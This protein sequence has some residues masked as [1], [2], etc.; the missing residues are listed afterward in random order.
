MGAYR[1]LGRSLSGDCDRDIKI[2]ISQKFVV[3]ELPLRFPSVHNVQRVSM[4]RIISR[5]SI[6]IYKISHL[7]QRISTLNVGHD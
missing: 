6:Y 3:C 7:S 5:N 4:S 1:L 2:T